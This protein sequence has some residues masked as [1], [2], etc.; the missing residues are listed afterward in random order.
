MKPL[1]IVLLLH[2]FQI[3]KTNSITAVKLILQTR[4]IQKE[5]TVTQKLTLI[6]V[7]GKI[8]KHTTKAQTWKQLIKSLSNVDMQKLDSYKSAGTQSQVDAAYITQL[9]VSK[10]SKLYTSNSFD[11][12]NPPKELSQTVKLMLSQ[13]PTD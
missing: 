3:S 1:L 7:N 9:Q 13:F 2:L 4:G 11:H 10:D 12:S 8:S 5:V 6:D